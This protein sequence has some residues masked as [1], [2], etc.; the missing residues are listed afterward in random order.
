MGRSVR[1]KEIN[2]LSG[3][4]P[5]LWIPFFFWIQSEEGALE[6]PLWRFGVGWQGLFSKASSQKVWG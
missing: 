5:N 2:L 1:E 4:V 6:A 3:T